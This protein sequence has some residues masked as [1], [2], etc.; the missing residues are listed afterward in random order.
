MRIKLHKRLPSAMGPGQNVILSIQAAQ[1]NGPMLAVP[2]AALFGGQDGRDYVSKVT[3]PNTTVRVSV[4]VVTEG[5]GLVGIRP[6][7]AGALKAGDRVVTGEN[8]LT[9]PTG[10]TARKAKLIP[11]SGSGITVVGPG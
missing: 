1:S 4:A 6:V 2:E 11:G 8:Y 9:S 5:D 10:R 3:G 7:T